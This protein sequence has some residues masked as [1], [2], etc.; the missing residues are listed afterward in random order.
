MIDERPARL[1]FAALLPPSSKEVE[2]KR[3]FPVRL[4]HRIMSCALVE[5][6]VYLDERLV[7]G[8]VGPLR[9]SRSLLPFN[10]S[11]LI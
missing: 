4:W 9:T 10:D 1:Q 3:Y 8:C 11:S 2:G 5:L 6:P 7:P